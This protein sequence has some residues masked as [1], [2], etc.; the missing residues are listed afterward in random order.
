[1]DPLD[2]RGIEAATR[3][4]ATRDTEVKTSKAGNEFGAFTLTVQ[5]GSVG[6]DGHPV[7]ASAL[8]RRHFY[9]SRERRTSCA[10][11]RPV[12]DFALEIGND[13]FNQNEPKTAGVA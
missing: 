4:T 13:I 1:M 11:R 5:D 9:F 8:R 2:P 12:N 3:G 7:I 10:G 6:N